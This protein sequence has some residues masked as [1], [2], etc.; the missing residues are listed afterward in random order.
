MSRFRNFTYASINIHQSERVTWPGLILPVIT[1][2]WAL[3]QLALSLRRERMVHAPLYSDIVNSRLFLVLSLWLDHWWS[4]M[5]II[6]HFTNFRYDPDHFR[7]ISWSF[8]YLQNLAIISCIFSHV[9]SWMIVCWIYGI[10]IILNWSFS[11]SLWN[12]E[13][14]NMIPWSL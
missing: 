5:I 9:W 12:S 1:R 7:S 3:G 11:G 10:L 13:G 8:I 4:L 6:D 2:Y 14:V